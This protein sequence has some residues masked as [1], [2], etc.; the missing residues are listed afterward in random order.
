[1]SER[2]GYMR[3]SDINVNAHGLTKEEI[4]GALDREH[5]FKQNGSAQ[6][7]QE[8][9]KDLMLKMFDL[10]QEDTDFVIELIE[11]IRSCRPELLKDT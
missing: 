10:I 6:D 1:V 9:R 2:G 5:Y 11:H 7:W 3:L 8:M 4:Q